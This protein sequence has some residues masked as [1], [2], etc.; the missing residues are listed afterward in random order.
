MTAAFLLAAAVLLVAFGGL[1]AA[2]DAAFAVRSRSDL[3]VL[4][5]EGRN[6]QA[7]ERKV[8][9]DLPQSGN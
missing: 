2:V 9:H 4:A 5:S 1:M 7:L 3:L 8:F 6:A